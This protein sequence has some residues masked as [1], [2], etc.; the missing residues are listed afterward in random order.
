MDYLTH[1][2]NELKKR[3]AETQTFLS[4]PNL[5]ELAKQELFALQSQL[6]ALQGAQNGIKRESVHDVQSARTVRNDAILE[7]RAAAGGDEAGLFAQEILRMY[8]RF[9]Q[10]KGWTIEELSRSEGGLHNL[11][12]VIVK[13]VGSS[14]FDTLRFE[15][16]THRVQRVP[17]TE[18][19][20]RIH[21]STAT[22]AVLPVLG[23]T[24]LHIRPD[25]IEFE[26]FR[27][28]GHGG[29]NVNKVSTAVRLK[30]KPTGIIVTC[31]TERQQ[32]QNRDNAMRILRARL[33]DIAE[34]K[35]TQTLGFERK[36]Q[37][38]TGD[39]SEKIRTYNFAQNRITDHRVKKSWHNLEEILDGKI[40]EITLELARRLG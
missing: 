22:V 5:S 28:S 26:A 6:S 18:S 39:R 27:A 2:I 1:Q 14:A 17:I 37:I 19:S 32:A 10:R 20:G 8:E 12:E 36:S 34:G 9:A 23:D 24:Q 30:H 3:I 25:D 13:I 38:G 40:D 31:Q 29:Q 7:I 33:W 15:S 35:R 4:D 16:G 11:K 21:T